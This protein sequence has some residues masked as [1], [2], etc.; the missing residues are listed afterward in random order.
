VAVY[1]QKAKAKRIAQPPLT[2]LT[3]HLDCLLSSWLTTWSRTHRHTTITPLDT[4]SHHIHA[5]DDDDGM[6][7]EGLVVFGFECM[8]V[9]QARLRHH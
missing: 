3:N 6:F 7:V 5:Q 4:Q 8:H 2:R 1:K 9:V